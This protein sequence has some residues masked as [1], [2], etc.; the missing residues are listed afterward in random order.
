MNSKTFLHTPR[1]ML[2]KMKQEFNDFQLD[3]TSSRHAIN[4]ALTAHHLKE[5]V[6]HSYLKSNKPLRDVISK[7]MQE[8]KDFFLF[9]NT[10]CVE[11]KILRSLANNIKHV[12]SR[13]DGVKEADKSKPWQEVTVPWEKWIVPW[14][15]KGL[16][17]TTKDNKSLSALDVFTKVHDYWTRC[18]DSLF[19]NLR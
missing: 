17:I 3:N 4:F 14:E 10:K 2:E 1:D 19:K 13:A 18:F 16:I 5:W 12:Q 9:L 15:Y 11:F 7:T 8:K 6:W